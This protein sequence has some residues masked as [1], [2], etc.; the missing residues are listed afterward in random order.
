MRTL[1]LVALV[2]SSAHL[3]G[4]AS[5]AINE[6]A[7]PPLAPATEHVTTADG[8]TLPLRRY[9]ATPPT[10]AVLLALHGFNDHSGFIDAPARYFTRHG[11]ETVA[12]DQRGFG[13]ASDRGHWGGT[14]AMADDFLAVL[15]TVRRDYPDLPLYALGTSMGAAVIAV[16]LARAPHA[17][18][19]GAVLV[20]PAVWSRDTMP[21]YQRLGIWL[22]ARLAPGFTLSS[23]RFNIAPS[24]NPAVR[25]AVVNDPLVIGETRLDHLDALTDLMEAGQRALPRIE[26]RALLLYGL[27]DVMMPRAPMI[28]LFERWPVDGGG[29]FRFALYPAGYH[30]LMRDRQ[31]QVVWD[32]VLSWMLKPDA[33]LPSGFER[34][35]AQVLPLLR[36]QP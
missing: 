30:V 3:A 34:R 14:N 11:I 31:R 18:V 15:K 27:R 2:L 32:D 29:H 7:L 25:A 8:V 4:R 20:T 1:L 26:H 28:A 13:A 12:F 6:G 10:R 19:D 33:G 35:R 17:S 21:W 5:S 23:T 9:A 22:G 36:E 16:A 24:D